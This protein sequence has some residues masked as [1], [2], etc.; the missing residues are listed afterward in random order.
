MNISRA[1]EAAVFLVANRIPY[2]C[3]HLNSCHFEVI[4]PE[5]P[6]EFWYE[7]DMQLLRPAAAMLLLEGWGSSHGT[8][9]EISFAEDL[10]IPV[11]FPEGR[12]ELVHWWRDD[13]S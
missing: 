9:K 5:V 1:R 4:V 7:M 2:F 11:F 6:L 12:R 8:R 13:P 10:G 3:P